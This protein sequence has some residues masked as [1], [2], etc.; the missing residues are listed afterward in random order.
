MKFSTLIILVVCCCFVAR[1][2]WSQVVAE[3]G[4]GQEVTISDLKEYLKGRPDIAASMSSEEAYHRALTSV[5]TQELKRIDLFAS[6]LARDGSLVEKLQR[7][8]TEELVLA[9]GKDQYEDKYLNEEAIREE[10]DNMGRVVT[11]HQIVIS[12][13]RGAPSAVLDSLRKTVNRIHQQAED[14]VPFETM[15]DQLSSAAPAIRMGAG[16][17]SVS[18]QQTLQNPRGY[19]I[20]HL[21]PGEVRSFEGPKSL[22]VARIEHVEDHP[23]PPFD[24]KVRAKIVSALHGWHAA[25]AT[26]AFKREWMALVDT[27]ALQWNHEALRQVVS[28]SNTSGFFE[29]N[30]SS[31]VRGYLADHGDARVLT[32]GRGEVLLSDLPRI[33]DEVLTLSRSGGHDID[34][35]KEFLL[36]AVRTER[37][38]E[39][40]RAMG[41][42]EKV[43]GPDTQSPVLATEFVRYYNQKR[44]E[45]RIP[46]PTEA[47]LRDFYEAYDD[48]LFYQLARVNTRIIVRSD[49]DEIEALWADIQQ[50]VPFEEASS[51][52]LRRSYVQT[53]EG[54]IVTPF[55]RDPP[56]LGEIVFGL[57]QGEVAGPVAFDLPEEGRRYALILAKDRLEERQLTFEEARGRVAEAFVDHLRQQIEDEVARELRAK[58]EVTIYDDVLERYLAGGK[59]AADLVPSVDATLKGQ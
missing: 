55:D 3:V 24:D 27:A 15:V 22:S 56:Y 12:K 23:P 32:D 5:V 8:M 7:N 9:Y 41:L 57:Q 1:P 31:T 59:E 16:E 39:R 44:I 37:L 34:S 33:F 38:A 45:S 46:E 17:S 40:A 53:R 2:A 25:K 29:G 47:E 36:E 19:I 4:E 35:I 10:Y 48:S 54:E 26:K 18:W 52:R 58:Y 51:R 49:K 21:S 13:P 30:Y 11:Y 28:W 20:F 50:G 43:W 6:G 42:D 14:G